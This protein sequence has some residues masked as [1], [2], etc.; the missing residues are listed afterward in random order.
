L[1]RR[2]S[3]PSRRRRHPPR[4]TGALSYDPPFLLRR[5]TAPRASLDHLKPRHLRHNRMFSHTT[6]SSRF[7]PQRKAAV[8]GGLPRLNSPAPCTVVSPEWRSGE[9]DRQNRLCTLSR[10][11]LTRYSAKPSGYDFRWDMGGSQVLLIRRRMR[12]PCALVRPCISAAILSH[13][14]ILPMDTSAWGCG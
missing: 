11:W 13:S 4:S 2:Q 9:G 12:P 7:I 8:A 5:P 14:T 1:A 10:R 3:V 6:M